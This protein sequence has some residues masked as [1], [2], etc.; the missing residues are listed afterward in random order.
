MAREH[1]LGEATRASD[2]F[3]ASVVL[4]ELLAGRRI[5]AGVT[6]KDQLA[7][8]YLYERRPSLRTAAEHVPGGVARVIDRALDLDPSKRPPNALAMIAELRAAAQEQLKELGAEA[9]LR[10]AAI[11]GLVANVIQRGLRVAV[12]VG[13]GRG[14]VVEIP[15]LPSSPAVDVRVADLRANRWLIAAIY[16]GGQIIVPHGT[17][18]IRAG[19]RLLLSGEPDILPDIA[20]YL[21]AGVARFPVQYGRRLLA[22]TSD[23]PS[24]DY[25]RELNYLATHTRISGL[26]LLQPGGPKAAMPPSKEWPVAST[27]L[28]FA[29]RLTSFLRR[30]RDT[31][32]SGCLILP[33]PRS[34]FLAR[35]GLFRPAY[36]SL[37]EIL[38]CPTL[39]A[40]GVAAYQR[41]VLAVTES[42]ELTLTTE[43]AVDLSRQLALP[44][45]AVT[46]SPPD[47]VSGSEH[48]A[49]QG[50]VLKVVNDIAA[51]YR[52]TV[53]SKHLNGNPVR[54]LAGFL[55][56]DDLLVLSNRSQRR[57]SLLNPDPG[58]LL[59]EH[60]PCSVMVLCN[61][62]GQDRR[63]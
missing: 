19:D 55:R 9:F 17:A 13:L 34:G 18:V 31:L 53:E 12:N 59:I 7:H 60:A 27:T 56:A 11:A 33:K 4:W 3:S 47:F 35:I 1:L 48:I 45:V 42:A 43:L 2:V 10:P 22:V 61:R 21:R 62:P 6:R 25:F 24:E 20:D 8:A 38:R 50:Q 37:F 16:R 41:V 44:L 57:A 23:Q 63:P 46:V 29:E 32:D 52:V 40:A 15:I 26:T 49:A 58:M 30:E 39:L 28:S 14:E 36:A 5:F 51:Q 54:E